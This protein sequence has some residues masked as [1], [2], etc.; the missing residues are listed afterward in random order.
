MSYWTWRM[1]GGRKNNGW[2]AY[3]VGGRLTMGQ[4]HRPTT[5]IAVARAFHLRYRLGVTF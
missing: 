5:K 2:F 3:I 1:R 4:N